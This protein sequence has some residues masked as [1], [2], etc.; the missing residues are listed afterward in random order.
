[1]EF[2]NSEYSNNKIIPKLFVKWFEKEK[3]T[4]EQ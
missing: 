3:K 4:T 2:E 1:M